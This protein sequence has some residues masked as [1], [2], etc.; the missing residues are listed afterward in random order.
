MT[1]FQ[2]LPRLR[3]RI[4]Y[5]RRSDGARWGEEDWSITRG[6]DGLRVL[7]A[8]CEMTLDGH[9]VVRDSVLSVQPDFHPH[10]AF[11]RI[12]RDGAVT[13]TGWFR[14]T[15]AEAECESWTNDEG[16]LRQRIPVTRPLRGF[17]IHALQGDGWLAATFP[18]ERGPGHRQF[19]GTN[20]L[21]STHHLGATGPMLATTTSGFDYVGA[22]T[23]VVPAGTFD[24]RRVAFVGFTNDHPPYD[25]WVST[26]GDFLYVRG[27]V[28]GYMNSVFEL[29]ELSREDGA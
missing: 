26:D 20:L 28:Q 9:N 23:A 7:T 17:G 18:Y 1:S 25:M 16:R 21:H 29:V 13:G 19:F 10:D 4:E 3:G 5:R 27:E 11:V 2:P 24:C 15:D 6:S 12:M 22:E 8:H 14:F